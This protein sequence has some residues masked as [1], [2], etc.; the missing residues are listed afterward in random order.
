M[1]PQ[2]HH[3]SMGPFQIWHFRN[4]A[5]HGEA[6]TQVKHYKLEELERKKTQ[7]WK[8]YIELQPILHRFQHTHFESPNTV[9]NLIYDSQKCWTA[10]PNLFLDEVASRS[11]S[12]YNELQPRYLTTRS[13]IG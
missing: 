6:N 5:F 11:S 8:R 7:I 2:T 9:N 3:C 13:G 10:L 4:A 12:T 1:G